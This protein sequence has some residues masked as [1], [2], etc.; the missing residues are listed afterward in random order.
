MRRVRVVLES[1]RPL[2]VWT[3]AGRAAG[4]W[5]KIGAVQRRQADR[6]RRLVWT[7]RRASIDLQKTVFHAS[8]QCRGHVK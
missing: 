3:E 5:A 2:G 4:V 7:G 8:S 6:R 1:W